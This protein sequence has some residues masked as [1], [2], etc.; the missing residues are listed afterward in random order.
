MCRRRFFDHVSPEGF[1]PADRVKENKI[2]YTGIGENLIMIDT[3]K[4]LVTSPSERSS[5]AEKLVDD[6]MN[7]PGHR[8]NILKEEWKMIGVGAYITEDDVYATQLFKY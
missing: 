8:A 3:N 4:T 1:G 7:S 6:W 5:L 2:P